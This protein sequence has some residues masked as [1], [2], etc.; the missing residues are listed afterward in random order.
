M[1]KLNCVDKGYNKIDTRFKLLVEPLQSVNHDGVLLWH[2][3]DEAEEV[4]LNLANSHRDL[5]LVRVQVQR[6]EASVL[7]G[8]KQIFGI[9][10]ENLD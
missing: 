8:S 6:G 4:S 3:T 5:L 10:Q 1:H 9:G 2:D 7:L